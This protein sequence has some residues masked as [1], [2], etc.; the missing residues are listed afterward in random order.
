[1]GDEIM[2]FFALCA[3]ALV[4]SAGTP[5][6]AKDL[7]PATPSWA[8][9]FVGIHG[10][11]GQADRNGCGDL[12]YDLVL[13]VF[14]DNFIPDAITSCDNAP[15]DLTFDY[16]QSGGLFGVQGGYNWT[17]SEMFLV[18]VELDASLTSMSGDLDPNSPFGGTATWSSLVTATAK[19][20]ITAGKFLIYGEG[21]VAMANVTFKNPLGCDFTMDHTGPVAGVGV[22]FKLN[23][24]ASIDLKYDHIWLG[25]QQASCTSHLVDI[26]NFHFDAPMTLLTQ[27]TADV[28]KIGLNFQLGK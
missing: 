16:T 3:A 7:T 9:G 28:V 23:D 1:M 18:G 5:V 21:G 11:Y 13:G 26:N 27:G 17:P 12:G 2:K 19:A 25:A 15:P 24:Q 10:G 6:A 22:S 20:G 14:Q 8:G 4:L